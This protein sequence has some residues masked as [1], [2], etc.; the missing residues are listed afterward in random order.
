MLLFHALKYYNA[1]DLKTTP[2]LG[3][4]CLL[5]KIIKNRRSLIPPFTAGVD[6]QALSSAA[7][8]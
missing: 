1:K 7:R 5:S 2:L 4:Q 6:M 8:E 3:N